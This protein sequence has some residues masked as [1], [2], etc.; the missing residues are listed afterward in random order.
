M[1]FLRGFVE[2]SNCEQRIT[3]KTSANAEGSWPG[4]N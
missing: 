3:T 2:D 1:G 4:G